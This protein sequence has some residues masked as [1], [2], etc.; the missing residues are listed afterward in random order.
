MLLEVEFPDTLVLRVADDIMG[1]FPDYAL[2]YTCWRW[3]YSRRSFGFTEI[4]HS[5][6]QHIIEEVAM[7]RA[8]SLLFTAK[9]TSQRKPP[10]SVKVADWDA[11]LLQL[12]ALDFDAFAQL[13]IHG[14]VIFK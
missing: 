8:F 12:E 9:W 4:D 7:R 10:I 1:H 2:S 5:D 11:W 13:A 3:S 6:K 14:E